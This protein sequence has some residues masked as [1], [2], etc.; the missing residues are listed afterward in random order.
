MANAKKSN[1]EEV[2]TKKKSTKK[3]TS[4][5]KS[6]TKKST[7]S[8]A[9]TK[10][11]ESNNTKTVLVGAS[12]V[13][14][15]QSD[16]ESTEY[17]CLTAVEPSTVLLHYSSTW[18]IDNIPQFLYKEDVR[19]NWQNMVLDTTYAITTSFYIKAKEYNDN[20]D[21]I[22]NVD[23]WITDRTD[24]D[25]FNFVITGVVNITGSS[26]AI[27]P[28][29]SD[30]AQS[31]MCKRL[32]ENC[33][34][35]K[36]IDTNFLPYTTVN[37]ESYDG[38]FF[39]CTNLENTPDLPA[40]TLGLACYNSMFYGCS[41]IT[42]TPDLPATTL[43]NDCY[44]NMFNSCT[45]LV[46]VSELTA[47]TLAEY[48]YFGM[49]NGCTSL[50]N[51]PDLPAIQLAN[52]CYGHMFFGCTNI[53]NAP[54]LPAETLIESCYEHMFYNCTRLK[55]HPI[56]A[57]TTLAFK[58]C[59]FM[60]GNCINLVES[61][62]FLDESNRPQ[63][64]FVFP[65]I[66]FAEN[67]CESMF[68]NCSSLRSLRVAFTTWPEESNCLKNWVKGVNTRGHFY[69]QDSTFSPIIYGVNN[70]PT[71]WSIRLVENKDYFSIEWLN[72]ATAEF[73]VKNTSIQPL[74]DYSFDQITWEEFPTTGLTINPNRR[75]DI[76]YFKL[77]DE[78]TEV[79]LNNKWEI[80][81]LDP[82]LNNNCYIHIGG[83][84]YSLVGHNENLLNRE[85]ITAEEYTMTVGQFTSYFKDCIIESAANLRIPFEHIAVNAFTRMFAN[86]AYLT[87][88]A[89]SLKSLNIPQEA[90]K[91]LFLNCTNL[92]HIPTFNSMSVGIRA[93]QSMFKG[94]AS[95][96]D[97][98]NELS[99]LIL[100][101]SCYESMFENCTNLLQVPT[102]L[103]EQ[104]AENCCRAM[105]KGCTALVIPMENLLAIELAD[106]CYREMF[107]DCTNLSATPV[108][109][110]DKLAD[111]C[112]RE[113]FKNCVNLLPTHEYISEEGDVYTTISLTA[114]DLAPHCYEEMFYNCEK[115]NSLQVNFTAWHDK[116]RALIGTKD[117]VYGVSPTGDYIYDDSVLIRFGPDFMPKDTENMWTLHAIPSSVGN[118]LCLTATK[119]SI[120]SLDVQNYRILV[121][122]GK[123]GADPRT[124]KWIEYDKEQFVLAENWFCKF[125]GTNNLGINGNVKFH[126]EGEVK[127]SGEIASILVSNARPEQVLDPYPDTFR[128]LF[129][130]CDITNADELVL[131]WEDLPSGCYEELFENCQKLVSAKFRLPAVFTANSS[132][133]EKMFYNCTALQVGPML[134]CTTTPSNAIT[135]DNLK[136][137][138][139]NCTSLTDIYIPWVNWL[140][141]ADH[142]IPQTDC[143]L[144]GVGR[145]GR[146][147]I[148][149]DTPYPIGKRSSS[150]L[151]IGWTIFEDEEYV[152]E[153]EEEV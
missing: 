135:R 141:N 137:M 116:K 21:P 25:E 28:N 70:I 76:I 113:M 30:T 34:G 73:L 127:L 134:E 129:A 107:K 57:A 92:I 29:Q 6:T 95:L 61:Q 104:V 53:I 103:A 146:I 18:N 38:M 111:S 151:P 79:Y 22:V 43:E 100:A 65:A 115:L 96:V 2:T 67:C 83:N 136:Y 44:A 81:Y 117:W 32:F 98:F 86:C 41:H 147:H 101:E 36:Q 58:S 97:S 4:T 14:A 50:V 132:A 37:R 72:T 150:F 78:L 5:T 8:K 11:A 119:P 52:T 148:K 84:I 122:Y 60:F 82:N 39:N 54:D 3:K 1:I 71:Y 91:E 152:E 110:G 75:E 69:I 12:L 131:C 120:V 45:S 31:Y 27:Y 10:K 153:D 112:Y 143:W 16:E 144:Q 77:K 26:T 17:I 55:K 20:N 121:G 89:I 62:T 90:Y 124:V 64:A 88:A 13:G 99:A 19:D 48:C 105:F 130:D 149:P 123:H 51:A 47:A 139:K 68:E 15:G 128:R 94:C 109:M 42:T 140:Y 49:F 102:I 66:T 126:V 133:Y 87:T 145:N 23:K 46:N 24:D 40:I 114:L 9:T 142:I 35:L 118:Y 85:N 106:S 7:T 63:Q 93:C 125:K 138:F 74:F 56:I 33:S 108:L 59:E 80:T